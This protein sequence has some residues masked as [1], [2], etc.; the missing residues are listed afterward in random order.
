[1]EYLQYWH[2]FLNFEHAN[3]VLI[4]MGALLF[5]WGV[6]KILGSSMKLIFW[7]FLAALGGSA[8]SYGLELSN[9]PINVSK[10]LIGLIGPSKDLSVDALRNICETLNAGGERMQTQ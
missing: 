10:E 8:F 1:M 6:L 9:V 3:L 7:V 5:F 4:G 2:Q